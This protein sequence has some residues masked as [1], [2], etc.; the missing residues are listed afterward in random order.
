MYTLTTHTLRKRDMVRGRMEGETDISVHGGSRILKGGAAVQERFR[1]RSCVRT[2]PATHARKTTKR[3]VPRN[4]RN[5]PES[6]HC[7]AWGPY[8][9]MNYYVLVRYLLEA[10]LCIIYCPK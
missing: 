5:S 8:L 3:G 1:L 4:Q 9:R 7:D 2:R 10:K 6:A